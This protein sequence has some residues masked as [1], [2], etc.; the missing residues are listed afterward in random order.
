QSQS[1]QV[2][3]IIAAIVTVYIVL[4]MLYESYVHPLTI[5]STLP[6]AGVGALLALKLFDK[7][8]SLVA[9]IGI[10]LLI[11]IV[12][13]NAIMMV[14]FALVAQ[15]TQN[16]SARDAI[17]QACQLRFRPIFMT[18][19]A[20]LLGALPLVI[21]SGDGAELRQ[22]LGITIVGGLVMSQLLTLY[23]TPVVYLFFDRLSQRRA[24]RTVT[25]P[26]SL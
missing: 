13:K 17:F 10:M 16:L 11:G 25:L 20:A 19:L 3:L 21:S 7:P 15:R 24:R 4:G 26:E 18:T 23:T 9:L 5:I 12:K 14:D 2:A 22:P 1:S 6:S 8:F